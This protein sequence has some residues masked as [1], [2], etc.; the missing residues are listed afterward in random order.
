MDPTLNPLNLEL[1][2]YK[3]ESK[4][5]ELTQKSE[6]KIEPIITKNLNINLGKSIFNS[7][8]AIIAANLDALSFAS[9]NIGGSLQ[10]TVENSNYNSNEIQNN[11]IPLNTLTYCVI[12][13]IEGGVN[14]YLYFRKPESVGFGINSKGIQSFVNVGLN[15]NLDIQWKDMI[16]LVQK[17]NPLGVDWVYIQNKNGKNDLKRDLT[18]SVYL[19]NNDGVFT[20]N[21]YNWD[22]NLLYLYSLF[23]NEIKIVQLLSSD[24]GLP[25]GGPKGSLYLICKNKK[26]KTEKL[27]ELLNME[28]IHFKNI[29]S[30]FIEYI[31]KI[32][33]D[34]KKYRHSK[35]FDIYKPFIMWNIPDNK[36]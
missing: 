36:I 4:D 13:D 22:I 19:L 20:T 8:S 23:Y 27:V 1:I 12:N 5:F 35:K 32:K 26:Y 14:E 15:I 16:M 28:E 10:M 7:Y 29:P 3:N 34:I 33:N 21:F 31:E 25:S 11:I 17:S 18:F 9:K 2:T 6:Y 30:D 24:N